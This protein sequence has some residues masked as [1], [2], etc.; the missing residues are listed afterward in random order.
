MI[1]IVTHTHRQ[2]QNYLDSLGFISVGHSIYS[3]T[4]MTTSVTSAQAYDYL[5][6]ADQTIQLENLVMRPVGATGSGD[7][8]KWQY[9][10]VM[11]VSNLNSSTYADLSIGEYDGNSMNKFATNANSEEEINI[12]NYTAE[13]P[14]GYDAGEPNSTETAQRPFIGRVRTN[15]KVEC[16][17]RAYLNGANNCVKGCQKTKVYNNYFFWIGTGESEDSSPYWSG[18][19]PQDP[20]LCN[21]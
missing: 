19:I 17:P 8:V 13:H 3:G 11:D 18:E 2:V 7:E 6:N 4:I 10:L 21:P 9:L 20:A 14:Y 15:D 12:F 1:F 16:A 5:W